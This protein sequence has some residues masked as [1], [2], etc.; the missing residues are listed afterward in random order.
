M[1]EQTI[2]G[3]VRKQSDRSLESESAQPDSF[4]GKVAPQ[5][6]EKRYRRFRGRRADAGQHGRSA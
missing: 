1:T 2:N 4:D 5:H 3:Q 6:V